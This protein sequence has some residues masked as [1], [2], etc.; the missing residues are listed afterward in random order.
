MAMLRG[1]RTRGAIRAAQVRKLVRALLTARGRE[2]LRIGV[3]ATGHHRP[4]LARLAPRTVIDVGANRGQFALDVEAVLP[5]TNVVSFEPMADAARAYRRLFAGNPLY[6][7]WDC[8]LGSSAGTS[9]L[10]VSGDDDS[11]S[12]LRIGA[13]QVALFPKS[14]ERETQSV[15]V[16]LMDNVI[17]PDQL[18]EPVFMKI[19]VQGYELEVLRGATQTLA[20]VHWVYV[21]CSFEELYEKQ[22]LA[23]EI[24]SWLHKRG[25]ML[26]GVGAVMQTRGRIVQADLMFE[27]RLLVDGAHPTPAQPD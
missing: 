1:F 18:V 19:D 21:E 23:G 11:S 2:A 26:S 8:A 27:K 9:T 7:I 14:A 17:D 22:P 24:T 15:T 4:V 12:L 25:F 20:N 3:V 6:S 16:E 5:D 10:H 13:G